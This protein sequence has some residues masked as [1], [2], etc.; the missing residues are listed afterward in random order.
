MLQN[1]I[2]DTSVD[3]EKMFVSMKTKIVRRDYVNARGQSPLYLH[4]TQDSRRERLPL[5]LYVNPQLWD[6]KQARVKPVDK[7]HQDLNLILDNIDSKIT[8]IRIMYRLSEKHLS[9][10][11]FVQ[12]FR[13]AI[14]RMDF[15]AFMNYQLEQERA[16]LGKGTYKKHKA[17]IEKLRKWREQ[18][19]FTELDYA[20]L[21]KVRSYLKHQGNADTTIESNMSTIK[22]FIG[23][24][25]KAGIRMALKSH[26]IKVGSTNGD[27]TDLKPEELRTLF[28][29]FHNEFTPPR[30][31]LVTGY[32]LFACFTGLRISD[33]QQLTRR[34]VNEERFMFKSVKTGKRQYISISDKLREILDGDIQLFVKKVSDVEMNRVLKHVA[35]ICKFEKHLTFHVARHSFATNFLR[36][37][38]KVQDLQKIL[39]HSEIR[40]T[41]IYVHIVEAEACEKI[42][43]M[44]NI[45]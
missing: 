23:A 2:F 26:E 10:E 34:Q 5:D 39:G 8:G 16:L 36:M 31:K 7:K 38:G 20:F 44:D 19:F 27:R 32:F 25:E 11:K 37:G 12:E 40:E 15:L 22:K 18:I 30:Y 14:P 17:V 13:N 42:K 6:P 45:F 24:A 35:R 33:V 41:M 29:Y 43:I 3:T 4:A 28:Q 21:T 1:S 9:L